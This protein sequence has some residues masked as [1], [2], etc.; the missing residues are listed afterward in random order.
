MHDKAI[1]D[2]LAPVAAG[3]VD[4]HLDATR[5]WFPHELVPWELAAGVEPNRPWS[6]SESRIPPGVRSALLV[7]LLTEDNLP[8]YFRDIERMFGGSEVWDFW[9]RRWT[10]EEGRHSIVIRD[11][12]TVTRSLC[13]VELER[14]RMAQVQSGGGPAPPSV[15]RGFAYLALQEL[16]T[17][18]AHRNTGTLLD[19][20]AGYEIMK[21]VAVDEN[22]HFLFYRDTASAAL[23]LCPSEMM[24]AIDVEVRGF[25]MPGTGIK[26]FTQHARA[27]A[28]AGI[29]DYA[30][31]HDQILE[32][33]VRRHWKIDS[34]EGL[35]PEGEQARERVIAFIE[36]VG[37]V[38]A[39]L[40]ERTAVAV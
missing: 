14:A 28:R 40:R 16:A 29:Y 1:L 4:R 22:H 34:L 23:E 27:I 8:Y 20:A 11:Y 33:V 2:E 6:E 35:T 18:I 13:P 37:R 39:R 3:M 38:G 30:I 36:R 24:M 32:P 15:L 31:H 10:A 9:N 7:N 26:D 21:R 12:V 19:D 5:E 25:E 17:R